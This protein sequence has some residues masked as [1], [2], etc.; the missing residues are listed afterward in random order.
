MPR[1]VYFSQKVPSEQNLVEDLVIE[2][3]RTYGQ[4]VYYIPRE[5]VSRDDIL[6]EEIESKFTD[7]HM[8]EMYIENVDGFDGDGSL[9]SKFGL[10]IREQATFV[11]SRR[12]W[13]KVVGAWDTTTVKERTNEG[14]LIYLPLTKSLF[15]VK[16]VENKSPFYQLSKVPV[17]KMTCQLFEYNDEAIKTGVSE[18]DSFEQQFATEYTLSIGAGN[19]LKY[20]VGEK[21]TQVIAPATV[22]TPA[23]EVYATVTDYDLD[24]GTVKLGLLSTNTG[25]YG[26]FQLDNGANPLVGEKSGASRPITKVW[27]IADVP[28]KTFQENNQQAQNA[29]FEK[30]ANEILVF[31]EHNPFGEPNQL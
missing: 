21:V 11:V 31:D 14:D 4:D 6:N 2:S 1:S 3:L 15:E 26:M 8:I 30:E 20:L 9:F 22:S 28:N 18:I 5:L 19:S 24:A 13:N 7:A 27:T 16:W 29:E 12:V 10:E 17:W 25:R 23:A